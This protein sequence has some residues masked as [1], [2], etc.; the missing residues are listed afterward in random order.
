MYE[1]FKNND[2]IDFT[3]EN[4]IIEIIGKKLNN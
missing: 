4:Q 1:Y 2:D 3:D